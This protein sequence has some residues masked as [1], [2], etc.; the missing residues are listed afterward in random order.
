ME[1]VPANESLYRAVLD[2]LVEGVV[3][4]D[5]TGRIVSGNRAAGEFLGLSVE[6]LTGLTPVDPRWHAVHE[7]GSPFAGDEH[8]AIVALATGAAVTDLV[9]GVEHSSGKTRWLVVNAR[10]LHDGSGGQ[11]TGAVASFR[12][13]TERKN[14]EGAGP[15]AH[16]RFRRFV[17]AN[18]IGVVVADADGH[19]VEANDY[20]LDLLGVTRDE[21]D[22]GTL[23]W[24]AFTPPEWLP[25][26]ERAI[27]EL[28]ER[29]VCSPYEKEYLRRDGHRV[30]V[31]I[32]DAL[33]P[34]SIREIAAFVLDITDRKRAEEAL[35]ESEQ[36]FHTLAEA[37]PQMV[38]T[39]RP[40][41]WNT[42]FNQR[43]VEY[44]GLTLEES[45]GDGWS[46]PFHPE[47]RER[48]QEAWRQA[49]ATGGT[50]ELEVRLRRA[51]G[52]YR[53]WLV[54]GSPFRDAGGAITKWVG[55]CTDIEDLRQARS[56][57]ELSAANYDALFNT[58]L[59]GIAHGEIVLDDQ[60]RPVDYRY[61]R[62]NSTF[63]E[64]TGLTRADVVGRTMR[65][66]VPGFEDSAFDFIG[67]HGKVAL[68]GEPV[69]FEQYQE[70]LG[71]WYSV[72]VYSP[73]RGQFISM[74][75]DITE[76]KRDEEALRESEYLFAASQRA[77]HVGTWSWKVG[78]DTTYWSDETYRIYG[79][80]PEMGP[81]SN[82]FF[83][84][85]VHPDD[86]QKTREFPAALIAGLH[87]PP[88][89]CRVRRSDGTYR[90][91]RTVGDVVETV[92]GVPSRIAGTAHDVTE[93]KR[94]EEQLAQMTRL[95]AT[96]SQV[97]QTIVRVKAP[98]ELYQSI[99]D[100]AVEFGEFALA[101][102]GL[103][104]EDSG[105]VRPVAAHGV[106]VARWPFET[107]N[108]RRGVWKDGLVATAIRSREVAFTGEVGSDEELRSVL[109]QTEGRDYHAIA[110][111][112]FGP[113][114][115]PVGVLV[116]VSQ[117]EGLFEEASEVGLLQEMGLDISFALDAMATEIERRKAEAAALELNETLELRVTERT[118]ALEAA[119]RE[120]EA[121]SYSV[122][123]DLR[124]PLR[125]MDGFSRIL[126]ARH[127]EQ[128]DAEAQR[129]LG[130]VVRS[131]QTMGELIDDLLE[132]S[133]VARTELARR[134]VDMDGLV[135][136]VCEALRSEAPE[137][138]I[139]FDV[140]S[141]GS[142]PGD[143]ALLRQVWTNLIGNALKFTRLV[144]RPRIEVRCDRASGVCRY[145]VR[146]N[147]AGFD[148]M[149]ADRLFQ[150]FQR[151]HEESE[152]EGAGIGL[153][154]VARIVQRHGGQVWAEGAPGVGATFGFSLPEDAEAT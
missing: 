13:I 50:Y 129:L 64:L 138:P 128:M 152:F 66:I 142:V 40:D 76:R 121:F 113:N 70:H 62:V 147:G 136:S 16:A 150:P 60:G 117:R 127:A 139:E 51:D 112:P 53:W 45:Y 72:H 57:L 74:F 41:G 131:A 105:D 56:G 47:D 14:A 107:V 88:F 151:L 5:A 69:E 44:T 106:D 59:L 26:D 145:T 1:Q 143:Q 58:T 2:N 35:R 111:I 98:A 119:N 94:A 140:G 110:A 99:C 123:H 17:D 103:H 92:D 84:E 48:A 146:D 100:V 9:M 95:Y 141:L 97:N 22:R 109:G 43:W 68:T 89:D 65:E 78:D 102:V 20:Y 149:H 114:E 23:D 118:A 144:E 52:V 12:D 3:V 82:E 55:T 21:F 96:L 86:R 153:A 30:P 83:F 71:R 67:V 80:S 122:S 54:R 124:A 154:I 85:I 63:E 27:A 79:L 10:P 29:G 148:A 19:V 125:H 75:S 73:R 4:H 134:P 77:A 91:I 135:R 28:R 37:M 61:V 90:T 104:D 36:E 132:F 31:L 32:T 130:N 15:L 42:Y 101:W 38:W 34:G 7:D 120:L 8:P 93:R 81:P 133:R 137:R 6:E 24:R 18:I 126:L 39:T 87:P 116:L 46:T 25:V 49:T 108:T 115:K 33:M 11:V